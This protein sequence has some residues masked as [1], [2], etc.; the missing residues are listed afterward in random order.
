MDIF[1]NGI[2]VNKSLWLKMFVY[3]RVCFYLVRNI[4]R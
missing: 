4:Y 3:I 1:R 2:Y